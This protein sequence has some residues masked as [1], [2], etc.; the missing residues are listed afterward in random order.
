MAKTQSRVDCIKQ[1]NDTCYT[2]NLQFEEV[3]LDVAMMMME[4]MTTS[5][6]KSTVLASRAIADM[7]GT[8]EM[9][10]Q[11]YKYL[12]NTWYLLL[13]ECKQLI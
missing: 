9:I 6:K 12:C 4:R 1:T 8:L 10:V 5:E 3:S 11:D 13:V 7:V 2:F